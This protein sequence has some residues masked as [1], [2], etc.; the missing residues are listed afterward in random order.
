VKRGY[1]YESYPNAGMHPNYY[2]TDCLV[3]KAEGYML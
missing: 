1:A 2:Y 3:S